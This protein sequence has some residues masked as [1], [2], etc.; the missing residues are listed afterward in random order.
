MLVSEL[1]A[2]DA[3][4][5][6]AVGYGV[7]VHDY[8][9]GYEPHHP[10][11]DGVSGVEACYL[12]AAIGDE[13]A[14]QVYIAQWSKQQNAAVSF[15]IDFSHKA[16]AEALHELKT[17][18]MSCNIEAY[19]AALRRNVAF[20]RCLSVFPVYGN[21]GD[22]ELFQRII[23]TCLCVKSTHSAVLKLEIIDS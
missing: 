21:C 3:D 11:V 17:C 23:E 4:V 15:R 10:V 22:I 14:S 2:D 9:V 13:F 16:G 6:I 12:H 8:G 7:V 19:V 20:Y 5:A 1:A 18:V